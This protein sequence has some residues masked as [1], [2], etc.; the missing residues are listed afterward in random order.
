MKNKK[1]IMVIKIILL[2]IF[3]MYIASLTTMAITTDD[4]F[5]DQ[6]LKEVK[7]GITG[8]DTNT[9]IIGGINIIIGLIQIAGTGVALIMISMLGIKYILAS[10]EEKA[11]IKKTALPVVIGAVLLFGAVN[12]I[13]ILENFSNTVIN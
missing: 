10:V 13:A 11:E 9:G 8:A 12:L 5:N 1:I 6:N 7:D 4:I 2:S 3:F